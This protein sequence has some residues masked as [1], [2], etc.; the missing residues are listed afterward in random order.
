M[1]STV[2]TPGNQNATPNGE[3]NLQYVKTFNAS[4]EAA[5]DGACIATCT[6]HL[7]ERGDDPSRFHERMKAAS[8]E[9]GELAEDLFTPDGRLLPEHR[10]RQI[11]RNGILDWIDPPLDSDDVL[12]FTHIKIARAYRRKGL[13][14]DL[15]QGILHEASEGKRLSAF[16]APGALESEYKDLKGEERARVIKE[17]VN[18]CVDF[19]YSLGFRRVNKTNWMARKVRPHA[20]AA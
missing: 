2:E 7:V 14:K 12:T 8:E 15:V 10:V 16:V 9:T 18:I 17:Q 5:P 13:G 6:A 4:M 20:R 1:P 19:W 11:T 3:A